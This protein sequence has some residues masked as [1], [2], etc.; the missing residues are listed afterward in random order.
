VMLSINKAVMLCG[1]GAHSWSLG[2]SCQGDDVEGVSLVPTGREF[3][4]QQGNKD[5]SPRRF[6][7]MASSPLYPMVDGR[8]L[9]PQALATTSSCRR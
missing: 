8:P 1:F 5:A 9:P 4:L 3:D 6:I 7:T 2:S